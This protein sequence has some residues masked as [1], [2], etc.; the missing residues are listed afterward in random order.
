M[1][2]ET[3]SMEYTDPINKEVEPDYVDPNP[4]VP[5]KLPKVIPGYITK[6]WYLGASGND[7]EL[8]DDLPET[9]SVF[10]AT[11]SEEEQTAVDALLAE[12]GMDTV[13]PSSE[14][15]ENM[16]MS[17]FLGVYNLEAPLNEA[18]LASPRKADPNDMGAIVKHYN[19]ET[20]LWENVPDVEIIGDYV[21]ASFTNLSPVAVM[22]Y[23]EDEDKIPELPDPAV[24]GTGGEENPDQTEADGKSGEDQSETPTV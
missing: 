21:Y 14:L 23:T 16:K 22:T 18:T 11:Y 5:E 2:K 1:T 10:S 13:F 24:P 17:K 6:Y 12:G 20:S 7:Q 15:P 4:T 8:P 3:S 19:S 9:E